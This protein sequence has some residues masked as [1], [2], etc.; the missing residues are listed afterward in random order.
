MKALLLA[1][2]LALPC[3]AQDAG[4][5]ADAPRV[6]RL[7]GGEI[8]PFTGVLL[9]EERLQADVQAI[10]AGEAKPTYRTV[11]IVGAVTL[12]LGFVA[13]VAVVAVVKR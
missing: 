9:T 4:T 13:G 3:A 1:A 8:A 6:V 5:P 2:L 7:S 10:E 11:A 12:V